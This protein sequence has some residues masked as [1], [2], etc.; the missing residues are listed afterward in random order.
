MNE[1]SVNIAILVQYTSICQIHGPL[2]VHSVC[3]HYIDI[4]NVELFG[5]QDLA[6]FD[7][8]SGGAGDQTTNLLI[9]E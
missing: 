7:M 5:V 8:W 3:V 6:H 4:L 9:S 1:G 2:A